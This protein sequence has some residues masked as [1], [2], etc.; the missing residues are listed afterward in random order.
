MEEKATNASVEEV[1]VLMPGFKEALETPDKEVLKEDDLEDDE[2]SQEEGNQSKE[3]PKQQEKEVEKDS[4]EGQPD[5]QKKDVASAISK[6][7]A[8]TQAELETIAK[9]MQGKPELQE[10]LKEENEKLY[11]KLTQRM[12]DIFKPVEEVKAEEKASNLSKMLESLINSQ[13]EK[14]MEAWRESNKLTKADFDTRKEDFRNYAITLV[15]EGMV[16]NWKQALDI[17]GQITFPHLAGSPVDEGKLNKISGQTVSTGKSTPE[18]SGYT[19]EELQIMKDNDLSEEEYE[20]IQ[21]GNV[22]PPGLFN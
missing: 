16:K 2:D 13:E 17:A 12:P 15:D 8:K 1:E 21:K 3:E 7:N 22:L 5:D 18:K 10:K 11:N 20:T 9:L 4:E 6:A 19:S 14:E